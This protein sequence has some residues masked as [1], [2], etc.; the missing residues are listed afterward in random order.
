MSFTNPFY[1][2]VDDEQ[3]FMDI[4]DKLLLL[5]FFALYPTDEDDEEE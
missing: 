4:R 3:S 2:C 5:Y 1:I